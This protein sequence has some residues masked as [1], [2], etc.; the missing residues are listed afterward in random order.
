MLDLSDEAIKLLKLNPQVCF[1]DVYSCSFPPKRD[2]V[3]HVDLFTS[4]RKQGST[5]E[6]DK[7]M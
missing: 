6:S 1:R 3:C 4:V 7:L 2:F 5:K